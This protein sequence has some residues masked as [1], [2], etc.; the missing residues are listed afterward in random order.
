MDR[1]VPVKLSVANRKVWRHSS[2]EVLRCAYAFS[3][4]HGNGGHIGRQIILGLAWLPSPWSCHGIA[5]S[6]GIGLQT[7]FFIG[8]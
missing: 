8:R 6:I 5:L 1:L 3:K 7:V 4:S 2:I